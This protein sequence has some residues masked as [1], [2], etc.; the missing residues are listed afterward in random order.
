M[1]NTI[2]A[3]E[4]EIQKS[5]DK[6][7]LYEDFFEC[8]KILAKTDKELAYKYNATLRKYLKKALRIFHDK[9]ALGKIDFFELM[10]QTAPLPITIATDNLEVTV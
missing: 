2:K 4:R 1:I 6:L 8:I 3:I 10:A 5:P 7:I 9:L